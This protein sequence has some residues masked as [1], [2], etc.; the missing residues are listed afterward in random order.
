[1][2]ELIILA[3]AIFLLIGF[4]I[5]KKD[6]KKP[7]A[8]PVVAPAWFDANAYLTVNPDVQAAGVDAWTHYDTSGRDEKR[9]PYFGND[10][11]IEVKPELDIEAGNTI[12]IDDMGGDSNWAQDFVLAV[13]MYFAQTGKRIKFAGITSTKRG[14]DAEHAKEVAAAFPFDV[15]A[16][17]GHTDYSQASSE[18]GR[19]IVEE[20]KKGRLNVVMGGTAGDLAWAIRNGANKANIYCY[21]LLTSWNQSG[22]ASISDSQRAEMKKAADVV[23]GLGSRLVDI[24]DP[25][26]RHLLFKKNLPEGYKDTEAFISRN[27]KLKVWDVANRNDVL[28][29]NQRLNNIQ[30]FTTGRLRIADVLAMGALFGIKYNNAGGI[31]SGCQHGIDLLTELDK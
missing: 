30:K 5:S 27:R 3:I 10:G 1:M 25:Q 13:A 29:E 8:K 21:A 12:Y 31:M 19:K 15:P 11:R 7:V 4:A 26:L 22:D 23:R 2:T 24:N 18:L 14:I 17:V 9:A 6:K 16:Y 20:S 28:V